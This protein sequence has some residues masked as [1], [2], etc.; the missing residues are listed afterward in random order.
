MSIALAPAARISPWGGEPIRV[1]AVDDAVVVRRT[2]AQWVDGEPDM[3]MVGAL[4]TGR[5]AVEQLERRN[6][7]VV[8]LD[9]AMPDIDGITALPLLLERRR[10]LVVIMVSTLTR[11][12]AEASLRALALGAADYIPKPESRGPAASDSFRREL[13]G[14]I[15]A[16][17]RRQGPVVGKW[18]RAVARRAGARVEIPAMTAAVAL[19]PPP[20]APPRVLLI[21]ASTGGPPALDLILRQ[22]GGVIDRAPVLVTQH[23][24]PAFTAILAEQLAHASGRPARLAQEGEPLRA[25][26]IYLA[27]GGGHLRVVRHGDTAVVALDDGA[28]VHFCKPAVDP[29]FSSAASVWGGAALALVLTGMGSDGLAGAADIVAAGGSVIVQDEASSVVWG[30]PGSVAQAGLACAVLSLDQ[31]APRIMRAFGVLP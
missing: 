6:P 18:A 21:G 22:I 17:G 20:V 27:G 11:R 30:M 1:M 13:I 29:L 31:I 10:D 19:R 7:H 24:P 9:I 8:I 23:M 14:K 28:P 26:A 15:R 25:G 2:I 12:S 5:E 16:L 3:R 4:G